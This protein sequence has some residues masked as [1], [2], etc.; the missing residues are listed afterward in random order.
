MSSG[1]LHLLSH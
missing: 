1:P